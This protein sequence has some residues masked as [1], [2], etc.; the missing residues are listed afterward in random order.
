MNDEFAAQF[1]AIQKSWEQVFQTGNHEHLGDS[2][3][4]IVSCACRYKHWGFSEEREF[5]IVAVPLPLPAIELAKTENRAIPAEKP[6]SNFL[7]NGVAVPYLDL[8]EGITRQSDRKFPIKRIIIGP[9]PD[10]LGRRLAVEKLLR[11]NDLE[12]SVAVSAIPYLG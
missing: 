12:A 6:V 5:R 4:T 8:F 1:D 9:H 10:K 2:D 3:S 11:Q 7:R